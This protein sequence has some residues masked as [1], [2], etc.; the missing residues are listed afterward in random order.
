MGYVPNKYRALKGDSRATLNRPCRV[1]IIYGAPLPW[2]NSNKTS[3]KL[4]EIP[5][6][7]RPVPSDWNDPPGLQAIIRLPAGGTPIRV[8]IYPETTGESLISSDPATKHLTDVP[9][10]KIKVYFD[11][12]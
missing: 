4:L 11:E 5:V 8:L 1:R 6:A 2:A 12:D 10:G 7:L 9:I 3:G